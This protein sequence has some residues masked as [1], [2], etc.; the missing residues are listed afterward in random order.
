MA[1]CLACSGACMLSECACQDTLTGLYVSGAAAT[2]RGLRRSRMNCARSGQTR[3]CGSS[4]AGSAAA[5]G[6]C[7][8]EPLLA[9]RPPHVN[10]MHANQTRSCTVR[11]S[12]CERVP[13]MSGM[14]SVAA[15]NV[16]IYYKSCCTKAVASMHGRNRSALQAGAAARRSLRAVACNAEPHALSSKRASKP[17]T[18]H[19]K[20]QV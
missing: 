15:C 20:E 17:A 5:L 13:A 14:T 8:L 9:G 3:G 19:Y 6:G 1:A 7:E 11:C 12:G 4:G 2:A 18:Q 10:A 16:L